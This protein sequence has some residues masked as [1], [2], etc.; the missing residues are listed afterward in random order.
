[1]RG[2]F[3]LDGS[4]LVWIEESFRHETASTAF[5][6]MRATAKACNMIDNVRTMNARVADEGGKSRLLLV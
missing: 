5:L 2:I 6:A 4:A 3:A 1:M